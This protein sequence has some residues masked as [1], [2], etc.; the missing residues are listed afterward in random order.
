MNVCDVDVDV[1]INKQPRLG[2]FS[3][4]VLKFK[5][6]SPLLLLSSLA[7]NYYVCIDLIW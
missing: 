6:C 1:E 3:I 7:W 4:E 2:L 5:V